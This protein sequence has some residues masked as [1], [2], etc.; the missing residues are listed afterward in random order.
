[1]IR[2]FTDDQKIM[3]E[4]NLFL[5]TLLPTLPF[6][7]L[8]M[9]AM[10]VGRGSGHTLIPTLIGIFRLWGI[11]ILLGYILT[12]ILNAGPWGIWFA[13]ALSNVIGG[14]ASLL[15]IRYGDWNKPII[16]GDFKGGE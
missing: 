12:F 8:F 9:V 11:R 4:T 14:V 2:V 7:G 6:F 10:S 1:M 15:W 13:M 3:A 16:K 5:E